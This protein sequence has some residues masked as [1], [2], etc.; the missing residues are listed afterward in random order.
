MGLQ[1][2]MHIISPAKFIFVVS[3]SL[4]AAG[5]SNGTFKQAS[6]NLDVNISANKS[7]R[8][9]TVVYDNITQQT[10][11]YYRSKEIVDAT[12]IMLYSCYRW[13]YCHKIIHC[14]SQPKVLA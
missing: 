10:K 3:H 14:Q 8:F 1:S 6:T 9:S 5:G 11:V 12:D 7:E 13:K 2:C 4:H